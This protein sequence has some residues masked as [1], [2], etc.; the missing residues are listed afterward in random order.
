MQEDE[1]QRAHDGEDINTETIPEYKDR[2]RRTVPERP[3]QTNG[4]SNN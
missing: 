1:D 3:N 4:R 2:L